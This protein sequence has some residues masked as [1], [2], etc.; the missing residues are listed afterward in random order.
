MESV[1]HNRQESMGF[2]RVSVLYLR[3]Y[4]LYIPARHITEIIQE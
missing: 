1:S 3:A 2:S 4:I